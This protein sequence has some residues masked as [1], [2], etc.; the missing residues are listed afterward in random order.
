MGKKV[1]TTLAVLLAAFP[2]YRSTLSN[3]K[4]GNSAVL[5]VGSDKHRVTRISNSEYTQ[6]EI[7]M[8]SQAIARLQTVASDAKIKKLENEKKQCQK[9][10]D[11]VTEKM[12]KLKDR[13]L[14][15]LKPNDPQMKSLGQA[16]KR[17]KEIDSELKKLKAA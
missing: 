9:T 12:K 3:L 6:E 8:S 15:D 4:V 7:T 17:L 1:T 10:I 14:P 2:M 13:K 16:R 11:A 5:K